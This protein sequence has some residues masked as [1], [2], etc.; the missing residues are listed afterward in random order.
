MKVI[1][2]AFGRKLQSIPQDY[3]DRLPHQIQYSMIARLSPRMAEFDLAEPI[4][5]KRAIFEPTH[6]E[7]LLFDGTVAQEYALTDIL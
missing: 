5:V 7:F 3:P 1:L 2:T 6:R 4:P